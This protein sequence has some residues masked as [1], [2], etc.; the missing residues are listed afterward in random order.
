MSKKSS[1]P[2]VMPPDLSTEETIRVYSETLFAGASAALS[3][4]LNRTITID[5]DP[6]PVEGID[7]LAER[8]PTPWAVAEARFARG[9]IGAHTLVMPRGEAAMLA[10]LM[11]GGESTGELPILTS[12]HEE[13]LRD[14]LNQMMSSASSSLKALLDRPVAFGSVDLKFIEAGDPWAPPQV[15][16]LV[17]ARLLVDGTP[18]ASLALTIPTTIATELG[19]NPDPAEKL[20]K[21]VAQPGGPT[22]GLDMILDIMLPVTVELGRTKMLIRDILALSP[23]SVLELEKLAGEP[24]DLLVN[25]R[26]IGK[27]EVVIID[28][29]FGVRLT[30]IS[31]AAERIQSLR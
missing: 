29:N 11:L 6:Q 14:M 27:G 16:S 8:L 28:E 19:T 31:R 12:E 22:P 17:M 20:E 9:Y 25:D 26:L 1:A 7:G 5:L 30:Q 21:V 3:T 2:A 10:Q 13:V 15:H 24:V 23:G 4:L 18:R